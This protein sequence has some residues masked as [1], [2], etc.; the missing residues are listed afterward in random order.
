[1][2]ALMTLEESAVAT[3]QANGLGLLANDNPILAAAGV[4]ALHRAPVQS[5][6]RAKANCECRGYVWQNDVCVPH[7]DPVGMH[8]DPATGHCVPDTDYTPPFLKETPWW[9]WMLGA[10]AV[11]GVLYYLA[12]NSDKVADSGG[13]ELELDE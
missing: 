6:A 1:M 13:D 10:I 3:V 12:K 5:P 7:G 4:D 9:V 11:A 8:F 2:D